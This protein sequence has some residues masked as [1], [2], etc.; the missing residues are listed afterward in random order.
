MKNSSSYE[1]LYILNI[2]GKDE[3]LKE[4]MDSIE[5]EIQSLGGKVTGVQK[6]DKR[7]FERLS[8]DLDS[9]FYVNFQFLIDPDKVD[10]LRQKLTLNEVVYRQFYLKQK[11]AALAAK[12]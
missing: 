5:K 1:G 8:G 9:G 10:A 11:E 12:A 6:M 4:A 2:Q 7:K 3:G